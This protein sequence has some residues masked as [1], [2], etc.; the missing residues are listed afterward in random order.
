[1]TDPE[2][3]LLVEGGAEGPTAI[4]LDYIRE[5]PVHRMIG[6]ATDPMTSLGRG[7]LRL[8]LD[9][10]LHEMSKS[11]VAGEYQIAANS[12]T[13]DP[14]L[15]PIERASLRASFS[16]HTLTLSAVRGQLFGDQ[17]RIAG[18]SKPAARPLLTAAGR[19]TA[20]G[21]RPEL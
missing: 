15:P 8:R 13:V 7:K 21:I 16:E 9:L 4:F 17:V 11:K 6:G 19:A 1:M 3:H 20:R 12:I 10:M 18:G 2:P 14:R 5:S